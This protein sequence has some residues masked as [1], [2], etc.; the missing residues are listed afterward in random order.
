MQAPQVTESCVR[1]VVHAVYMLRAKRIVVQLRMRW[2]GGW[3]G[4]AP[5]NNNASSLRANV[6]SLP[7]TH[8]TS[9]DPILHTLRHSQHSTG[10]APPGRLQR[11]LL[12][13]P[14]GTLRD[15]QH[16]VP[17]ATS[18][19]HAASANVDTGTYTPRSVNAPERNSR[20]LRRRRLH[21]VEFTTVSHAEGNHRASFGVLCSTRATPSVRGRHAHAPQRHSTPVPLKSYWPT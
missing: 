14:L 3:V 18:P 8:A 4:V 6:V 5:S 15:Q 12:Q 1:V 21:A 11:D 9:H 10:N 16:T 20:D 13:V 17:A 2:R 7:R 19:M